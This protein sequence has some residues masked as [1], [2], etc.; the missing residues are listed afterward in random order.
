MRPKTAAFALIF[1]AYLT[2]LGAALALL[3][4]VPAT[5]PWDALLADLSHMLSSH[6]ANINLTNSA[7]AHG[8]AAGTPPS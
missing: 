8:T 1:V 2:A 7:L 3:A 6:V 5:A 4:G